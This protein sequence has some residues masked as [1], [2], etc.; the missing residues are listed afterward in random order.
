[1]ID[2]FVTLQKS[3]SV[4]VTCMGRLGS[5]AFARWAGWFSGQLERGGDC[6]DTLCHCWLGW[7]AYS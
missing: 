4:A 2:N 3:E 7:S 5:P 6:T 1:M